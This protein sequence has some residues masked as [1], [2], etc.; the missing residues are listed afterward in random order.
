MIN[1]SV[2]PWKRDSSLITLGEYSLLLFLLIHSV[3]PFF[4]LIMIS[5][6]RIFLFLFNSRIKS[7]QVR[8]HLFL[9][10]LLLGMV[11][12]PIHFF[13]VMDAPLTQ[14]LLA[15]VLV[16]SAGTFYVIIH[17]TWPLMCSYLTTVLL[18]SSSSFYVWHDSFLYWFG[19]EI[20]ISGLI[21]LC[22]V[23]S[24]RM[25]SQLKLGSMILWGILVAVLKIVLKNNEYF[26]SSLL[27]NFIV[28]SCF[29][30]FQRRKQ[31]S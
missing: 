20:G 23:L 22:F 25:L 7:N 1:N 3:K 13:K 9:G 5:L 28:S 27:A 11:V 24:S 29:I 10:F 19:P 4:Y 16:F 14:S 8:L 30:I 21:F 17:R 18:F 6:Y 15:W 12:F 26:Y 31:L 2:F